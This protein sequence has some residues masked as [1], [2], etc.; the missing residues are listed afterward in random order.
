MLPTVESVKF[1]VKVVRYRGTERD[2]AVDE[3]RLAGR[4]G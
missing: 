2:F 1:N 4:G 3:T